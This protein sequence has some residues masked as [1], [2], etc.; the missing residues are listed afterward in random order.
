M[1]I[2]TSTALPARLMRQAWYA[3]H[4]G[5]YRSLYKLAS[6]WI[7]GADWFRNDSLFCAACGLFGRSADHAEFRVPTC[8]KDTFLT[9]PFVLVWAEEIAYLIACRSV[10]SIA[11]LGLLAVLCADRL[12]CHRN[13]KPFL[14]D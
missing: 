10:F 4:R 13:S 14:F 7:Y 6:A 3:V 11:S 2:A 12:D 5:I 1:H 9:M 8:V